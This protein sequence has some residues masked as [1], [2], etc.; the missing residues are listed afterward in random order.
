MADRL[1]AGDVVCEGVWAGEDDVLR[2]IDDTEARRRLRDAAAGL[3][4]DLPADPPRR[5]DAAMGHV[6][7]ALRGLVPGA[8]VRRWLEEELS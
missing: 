8:L 4:T 2:R 6:M 5:T 1:A 3:P 7:P